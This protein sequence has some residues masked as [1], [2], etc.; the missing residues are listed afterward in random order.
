MTDYETYSL[1]VSAIGVLVAIAVVITAIWGERLRQLWTKPKLKLALE[2][3]SF[4]VTSGGPRGWYYILRVK[5]ERPSSPAKNV[6]ILLTRIY[7]R[8]PNG[9][10]R[11][12][13]F[14]GPV[15]VTWRWVKWTPIYPTVGPDEFATFGSLIETSS[16]IQ[17]QFYWL[18]NNL[19][20]RVFPNDPTRLVYKAVSDTA[21]SKALTIEIVWNGQWDADSAVME[22]NL[23]IREITI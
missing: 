23:T 17:L 14:S 10:W 1:I 3:P 2:K 18:P 11:E 8:G 13:I 5:N 21:D 20:P 22:N 16:Y 12:Q 9:A 15:P 4:N 6:L 7:K 19:T